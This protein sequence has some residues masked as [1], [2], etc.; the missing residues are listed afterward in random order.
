MALITAGGP[1]THWT[2]VY[3]D[4]EQLFLKDYARVFQRV[5]QLGAGGPGAVW[6]L[7]P[8]QYVWL[9]LNGT[10]TNFGVDISPLDSSYDE[11]KAKPL[12]AKLAQCAS[13]SLV[14]PSSVDSSTACGSSGGGAAKST[15]GAV[16]A[17]AS[18]MLGPMFLVLVS[19]LLLLAC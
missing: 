1:L 19:Q 8:Q 18:A 16:A 7:A 3:A 4:N 10:A 5:M 2:H 13:D 15:S 6:A 17:A 12:P 9:G 14:L 11:S